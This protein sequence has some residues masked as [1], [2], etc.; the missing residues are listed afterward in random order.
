MNKSYSRRSNLKVLQ[1]GVYTWGFGMIDFDLAFFLK[2]TD[3]FVHS[4]Q[5][6]FAHLCFIFIFLN[7]R[8]LLS[9]SSGGQKSE[10]KVM[11]VVLFSEGCGGRI[12][13]RPFFL[14]YRQLQIA[15][16]MFTRQSPCVCVCVCVCSVMFDSLQPHGLQPAQ[17]PL[18]MGFSR[19]EYWTEQPFPSL[20]D[21]PNPGI[22][23]GSPALRVDSLLSE[24]PRSP[25]IPASKF[26][27]F[28]KNISLTRLEPTLMSSF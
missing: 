2:L 19:K 22:E 26:H 14:A 24:L 23:H 16:L 6:L 27:L 13:S 5:Y 8:N 1:L 4:F 17:A 11:V 25:S 7:N 15:I 18:S 21:L 3:W 9:H 12:C 10:I 28:Y 20:G